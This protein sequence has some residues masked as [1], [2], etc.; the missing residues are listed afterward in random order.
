M[1]KNAVNCTQTYRKDNGAIYDSVGGMSVAFG[2]VYDDWYG[3]A[4]AASWGGNTKEE[5]YT[6]FNKPIIGEKLIKKFKENEK[7]TKSFLKFINV[8]AHFL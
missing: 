2:T 1:I 3:I 5:M 6:M 8:C 7:C 4:N